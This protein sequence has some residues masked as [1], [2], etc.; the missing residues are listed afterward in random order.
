AKGLRVTTEDVHNAWVAWMS[1]IDPT[2]ESL[3]PFAELDKPTAA[4]D[5]PYVVAI[6]S[7]AAEQEMHK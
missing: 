7:V 6:K 1:E 5:E 4:D 3:I 2:H